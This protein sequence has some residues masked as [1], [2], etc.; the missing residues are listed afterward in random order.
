MANYL[1]KDVLCEAYTHLDIDLY[2]DKE[3]LENLKSNMQAFLEDRAKFLFG[4]EVTVKVSFD[5]GSLKTTLT[6]LGAVTA[7]LG[8]VSTTLDATTKAVDS[9]IE[10]AT[11]AS[12]FRNSVKF[13]SQDATNLA[14]SANLELIFRTKTAYCDRV[15]V[16]KRRGIFGRVDEYLSTIESVKRQLILSELPRTQLKLDEFNQTTKALVELNDKLEKFFI[17]TDNAETEAC[18][19]AGLWEEINTSIPDAVPWKKDATSDALKSRIAGSDPNFAGQLA[20]SIARYEETVK[21]IKANLLARVKTHA[22]K[23]S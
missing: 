13:L 4:E 10:L 16:E 17:K 12:E 19:S 5:E 9:A 23:N 7:V 6:V 2:T 8:A 15:Y 3:Q 18:L 11:S 21:Q 22:P 1:K 14:Q 20:G